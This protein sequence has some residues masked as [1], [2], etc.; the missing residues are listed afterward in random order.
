MPQYPESRAIELP[1]SFER[2]GDLV[3]SPT[4][5]LPFGKVLLVGHNECMIYERIIEE[6][7]LLGIRAHFTFLKDHERRKPVF[8]DDKQLT[9]VIDRFQPEDL[10]EAERDNWRSFFMAG[11]MSVTLGIITIDDECV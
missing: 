11:W 7:Y 4:T 8:F 5:D 9:L 1:A 6:G 2:I 10:T 3:I